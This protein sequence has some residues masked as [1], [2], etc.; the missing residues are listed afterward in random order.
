[1]G[2]K[3]GWMK[4]WKGGRVFGVGRSVFGVGGSVEIQGIASYYQNLTR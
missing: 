4:G 1:M 3:G 2:W